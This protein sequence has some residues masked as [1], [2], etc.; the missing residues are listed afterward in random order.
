MQNLLHKFRHSVKVKKPG[1]KVNRGFISSLFPPSILWYKKFGKYFQKLSKISQ[2]FTL[3]KKS[4]F[5]N[6]LLYRKKWMVWQMLILSPPPPAPLP[7][8][9]FFPPPLLALEQI[10]P[11]PLFGP[12]WVLTYP[13]YSFC[14]NAPPPPPP[15]KL[16]DKLCLTRWCVFLSMCGFQQEWGFRVCVSYMYMCFLLWTFQTLR[17]A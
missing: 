3:K 2:I 5:F 7:P 10:H 6:S 17:V 8:S 13:K 1:H 16:E 9:F 12:V 14:Y 11:H 4:L 15:S